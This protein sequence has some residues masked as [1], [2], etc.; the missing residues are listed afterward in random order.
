MSQINGL[1]GA[2]APQQNAGADFSSLNE[3]DINHFLELMITEMQNQ[4]PLEPMENHQILQ[5]ISQIREVGAT[6]KLTSTLEAVLL[7]QNV[8]SAT[9]LI[10]K[11]VRA[12]TDAGSPASGIVELVTISGGQPKLQLQA[13]LTSIDVSSES[14]DIEAGTY[15]YKVVFGG[16]DGELPLAVDIGPI[17]TTGNS[18][19]DQSIVLSNLP[20]TAGRK[21]IYRTDS[22]GEGDYHL[23]NEISGA[24]S[25]YTDSAASENLPGGILTGAT[26][27]HSGGRTYIVSLSNVAEVRQPTE[28]NHESL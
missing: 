23:V 18:S 22:S 5:Q 3:L 20:E 24:A 17:T 2:L 27:P 16:E 19:Y 13:D 9:N 6:D 15:Q 14:G 10:G 7:G 1:A 21:L 11:E 12:I 8:S 4:D 28:D 25:S 26:Q